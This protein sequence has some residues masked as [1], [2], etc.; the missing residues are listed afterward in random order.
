[1]RFLVVGAGAVGGFVTARLLAAGHAVTVLARGA[2]LYAMRTS[3]LRLQ[4]AQQDLETN[5]PMKL[6]AILG[7]VVELGQ[8]AE[9]VMPRIEALL[10]CMRVMDTPAHRVALQAVQLSA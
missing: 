7:A 4:D 2:H 5:R 1:M 10:A 9:V 3:G 8:R 6:D